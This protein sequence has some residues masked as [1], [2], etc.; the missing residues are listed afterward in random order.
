M[1]TYYTRYIRSPVVWESHDVNVQQRWDLAWLVRCLHVWEL[2]CKA[3]YG[4]EGERLG[5]P[6][7]AGRFAIAL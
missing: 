6:G 4:R 7:G 5:R 1:H 3:T 2:G